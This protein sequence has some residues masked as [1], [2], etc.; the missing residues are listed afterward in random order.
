MVGGSTPARVTAAGDSAGR[1][2][3]DC[4]QI[5]AGIR[6]PAQGAPASDEKSL[7][8]FGG[9]GWKEPHN[10][11]AP[12]GPR[13]PLAEAPAPSQSDCGQSPRTPQ[14]CRGANLIALLQR[15]RRNYRINVG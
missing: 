8:E 2:A 4:S 7:D 15:H 6:D 10:G 3:Q 1:R 5:A 11:R 12:C 13:Q 9:E 14:G